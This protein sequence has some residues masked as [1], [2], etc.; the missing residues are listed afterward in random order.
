M[1]NFVPRPG[2]GKIFQL[3]DMRIR[4]VLMLLLLCASLPMAAQ[5]FFASAID[6]TPPQALA[7]GSSSYVPELTPVRSLPRMSPD[8]A[9]ETYEQ[10][11]V[12]QAASLAE[13]TAST[14]IE[15]QLP[16]TSQN[17]EYEL[18]RHYVAPRT[19]QFTAIRFK[20]DKFVKSNVILRMLQ[21]EVTHVE[22]Q[23]APLT[24]ITAA[25]YKFSYKGL[26]ELEGRP[27]HVFALK[28]RQKRPGLFKGKIYVDAA[29]G[30]L[31]RAEGTMVKNPSF[32]IKNIEFVQDY[33][34]FNDFTLPVHM[35]SVAKTRIVGRAVVDIYTRDYAAS[36][37]TASV[38]S[39]VLQGGN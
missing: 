34:A 21:S 27:V 36:V 1:G 33:A 7:A 11:Y 13:Y 9:L 10:R 37:Q 23:E 18:K 16:D 31:R 17:G 26:E 38:I 22:K 35:H 4:T 3:F 39:P 6:A 15:A 29:T 28:P 24:A 8:L 32:F 20:G 19:L 14:L 5:A 30:S 25:N 12:R 2:Q